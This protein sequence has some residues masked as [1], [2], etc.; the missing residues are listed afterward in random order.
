[1]EEEIKLTCLHDKH[2]DLGAQMSPFAGYDM[3]IQ[4]KGIVEEHN[5]VREAV[6]VFD[7]SHMG[8]VRVKGPEAEKYVNHIFV[9]DVTVLDYQIFYGMM[10]YENGGT[11]DDLLVYKVNDN[12]F[13]L[14]INAANIDKDVD[15]IMQ[16]AE[17][18]DVE[19]ADESLYYGEVAVQ[20]RKRKRL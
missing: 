9:N 8:E 1:M 5:A 7:V 19:I 11:V 6:G 3:P 16:N 15:W 18:F 10:C 20:V 4:Y 2:V 13:F 14:V 12:E 17:G